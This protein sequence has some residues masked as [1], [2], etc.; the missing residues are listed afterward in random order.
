MPSL[1]LCYCLLILKLT[2]ATARPEGPE[3]P[4]PRSSRDG[5]P[6]QQTAVL[7]R[8]CLPGPFVQI[9]LKQLGEPVGPD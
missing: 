2:S 5:N 1:D 8:I 3:A 9:Y 4:D 6:F 7:A